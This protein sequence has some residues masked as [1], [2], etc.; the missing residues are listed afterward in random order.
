MSLHPQI[1]TFFDGAV[2]VLRVTAKNPSPMTFDGTNSYIVRNAPRGPAAIID[3]GPA[4]SAHLQ[5]LIALLA[6]RDSELVGIVVTHTHM[7]HTA[8]V[9]AL[10]SA[11]GAPVY[12]FGAHG[13]GGR[14]ET[15][16]LIEKLSMDKLLIGGGEGADRAF[17][18]DV[19]LRNNDCFSPRGAYWALRALHT[20]GHLSNHLCFDL[21]DPAQH[22]SGAV[23][24]GDHIM[25]W[26]TSLVSPPDGD[27]KAYM[28]SLRLFGERRDSLHLPGHGPAIDNPDERVAALI[29]HRLARRAAIESALRGSPRTISAIR[30]MV[31]HDTPEALAPMAER[32]ILAH[33]LELIEEGFVAPLTTL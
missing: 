11:T 6:E 4:L 28:T 32:N 26:A 33:I 7:D 22:K 29:A 13:T 1:W 24:T 18:A 12:A 21:E 27:M 2:E 8:G 9:N 14:P 31:Y 17:R 23:F 15:Q 5:M 20:P 3:P 25:R 19:T 16:K 10:A 30:A